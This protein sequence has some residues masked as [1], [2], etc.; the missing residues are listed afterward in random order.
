MKEKRALTITITD[1]DDLQNV[2]TA[3]GNLLK[4]VLMHYSEE[5]KDLND[6]RTIVLSIA[7]YVG[8]ICQA[9]GYDKELEDEGEND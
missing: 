5:D 1:L 8:T 3:I 9:M 4:E 2:L 7:T 6:F